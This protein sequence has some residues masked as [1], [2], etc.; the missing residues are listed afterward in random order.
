MSSNARADGSMSPTA[1]PL[2]GVRL[3]DLTQFLAGPFCTQILAD[4]GAE[5]IKI[6]FALA[7]GDKRVIKVFAGGTRAAA[8]AG[9]GKKWLKK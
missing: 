3:L 6:E 8:L 1:P 2:Q 9:I 4:I 5:I 7:G